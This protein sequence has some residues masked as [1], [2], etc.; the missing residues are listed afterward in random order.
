MRITPAAEHGPPAHHRPLVDTAVA[1][2]QS[3]VLDDHRQRSHGL[4]HATEH[5]PGRQMDA[6]PHLRAGAHESV[7]VHHA[8]LAHVGTH[9]DVGRRHHDD[10]GSHVGSAPHGAATRHDTHSVRS[11]RNAGRGTCPCRG[12]ARGPPRTHVDDATEAE[13]EQDPLLHPAVHLPS[14]GRRLRRTH[15]ARL[16]GRQEGAKTSRA[17]SP[18]ASAGRAKRA[19]MRVGISL[20][21]LMK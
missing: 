10:T 18:S 21:G 15:L 7:G 4:E 20:A 5:G 3:I 17:S 6:P 11:R 9:V 1:A 16:E 14:V 13:A 2:D 19:S 12:T 8:P